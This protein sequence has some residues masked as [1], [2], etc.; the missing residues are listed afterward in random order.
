V[1]KITE[2]ATIDVQIR[3]DILKIKKSI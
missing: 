2:L 1:E 3:E